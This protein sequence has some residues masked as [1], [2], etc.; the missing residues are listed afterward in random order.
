MH[1]TYAQAPGSELQQGDLLSRTLALEAILHSYHSYYLKS[2]YTH[3]L[4]LTQSCD[5]T[6]RGGA[7]CE[8]EYINICAVRP[9][10]LALQR[11]A[12]TYQADHLTRHADAISTKYRD[13]LTFGLS[14]IMNNNH[15]E[16]FY[17]H[18]DATIGLS[19]RSCAFLRLSIA[20]KSI[21]HYEQLEVARIASLDAPFQAK[22]G[23]LVGNMYG[24]VGTDDWV[25]KHLAKDAWASL[26]GTVLDDSLHWLDEQQLKSA[27]E[28]LKGSDL[29]T[30]STTEL[31]EKVRSLPKPLY[32]DEVI[33][34][35]VTE[36]EKTGILAGKNLDK[37]Q[38]R[39]KQA[40]RIAALLKR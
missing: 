28:Q 5:L 17:L 26:V 33:E 9:L 2:D 1:F 10:R 8:A 34:A 7:R 16:Y 35:V 4:I 25:P 3:F 30:L 14:R 6:K 11:L 32:K 24:R 27:K 31:R 12:R 37:I 18:E 39:L 19:D 22:L 20:V 29:G 23:W 40:P 36:L 38:A 13:R 21:E 15:P